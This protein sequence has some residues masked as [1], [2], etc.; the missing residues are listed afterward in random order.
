MERLNRV[1]K[2]G[3][4]GAAAV[5]GNIDF[6]G[7]KRNVSAFFQVLQH[8]HCGASLQKSLVDPQDQLREVRVEAVLSQFPT[9]LFDHVPQKLRF[10]MVTA[11]L[12]IRL[13]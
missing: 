4:I 10:L 7:R 8:G 11:R 6:P 2:V 9:G 13:D 5:K 12:L 1:P 3:V